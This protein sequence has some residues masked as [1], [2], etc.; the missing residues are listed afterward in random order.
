MSGAPG[1][2]AAL[3]LVIGNIVGVGIFTTSGYLASHLPDATFIMLA[4]ILGGVYAYS[5]ARVYGV[6][7]AEY[8]LTGGDYQ[9]L[10]RMMHPAAGYLFAWSAFFVTYTGSIAALAIGAAHYLFAAAGISDG[11]LLGLISRLE[12]AAILLIILFTLLNYRGI[13]MSA[14]VQVILTALIVVLLLGF[15]TSGMLNPRLEI[16]ALLDQRRS[17]AVTF[18]GFLN[19]L[20]AVFFT[21]MGWTTVVYVAGELRDSAS[22]IPRALRIGVPVVIVLYVLTNMMYL[23]TVPMEEAA[24]TVNIATAAAAQ[25]WGS[26]GAVIVSGFI[27]IAILSSLN[28]AILSGPGINLAFGRDGFGAGFTARLHP[29]YNS[30]ARALLLQAAWSVILVV[31]GSFNQLL[32]FV[33]SVVM[34][35]SVLAGVLSLR[36]LS[37]KGG[38]VHQI[39]WAWVYTVLCGVILLNTL[40]NQMDE[41]LIGIGI[42]LLGV[43]FY[44][45]EKYRITKRKIMN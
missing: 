42:T 13:P 26:G 24:N 8:P 16:S 31:S 33:M 39:I 27:F 45:W 38:T 22:M 28:S 14:R 5:G 23:L 41:A 40:F 20:I 11:L 18:S 15:A 19:S 25:L 32:S 6:L 43:P 10:S 36:I 4:W 17:S 37:Q 1:L 2:W 7:V 9:Y 35:F 3:A 12:V 21:Y 44:L 34:L 30:A 29:R